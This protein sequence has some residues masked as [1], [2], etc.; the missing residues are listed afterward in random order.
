VTLTWDSAPGKF[1]DVEG[2]GDLA[3]NSWQTAMRAIT[4]APDPAIV[5]SASVQSPAEA[6]VQYMR[7]RQVGP[8]PF[9]ETS[10]EDGMGDWTVAGDGTVWEFG[11]PTSGPGAANTGSGAVATGLAGD[12]T[13]GTVTQ[14]RTPVIDPGE[15]DRVKLEFS[16]FLQAAEGHGGQISILEADGTVIQSLE[17]LY[18]GG[19]DDTSEWTQEAIRLPTLA[20]ARPFIVQFAFLSTEDGDP[21]NGAGW[22]IDDVR[23]GK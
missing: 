17:K 1:Y 3:T 21:N 20:P 19:Q 8:P 7:V 13:D 11:T 10:F 5:T 18:L 23:I 4:A 2:R 6:A 14:L 15:T 9:L 16:Y 22:F 12:Y